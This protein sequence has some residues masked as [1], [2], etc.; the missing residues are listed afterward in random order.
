MRTIAMRFAALALALGALSSCTSTGPIAGQL[1]IPGQPPQKVTLTYTTDR[2]DEGGQLTTTLPSGE[3]F[4]GRFLQVTSTTTA[5]SIGP[6]WS[7]FGRP[8]WDDWGPFGD[9]WV[10]GPADVTTFRQQLL[11]E[12]R[13]HALRQ[14][15]RRDALPVPPRESAGRH[16]GRRHGRVPALDR[17]QDRRP[18][19]TLGGGFAPFR[20]L[21]QESIAPAN[22][23]SS[24]QPRWPSWHR[25]RG[26]GWGQGAL[27]AGPWLLRIARRRTLP[28]SWPHRVRQRI[29]TQRVPRGEPPGPARRYAAHV[30]TRT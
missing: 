5:D 17:R 16:A 8:L 3:S 6:M 7:S 29:V 18:V 15:R 1:I 12:G 13:G 28:I 22:R 9:T 11:R 27:P 20:C 30:P 14:P 25:T 26:A 23:R 19:L 2:Y 4:S 10:T 24:A 21:P